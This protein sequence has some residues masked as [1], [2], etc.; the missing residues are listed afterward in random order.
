MGLA[1]IADGIFY[2]PDGLL[3]K[4][5]RFKSRVLPEIA[6]TFGAG[7]VTVTLLILGGGV[8]SYAIGFVVES[9]IRCLLTIRQ[10]RK[11]GWSLKLQMSWLSLREIVSYSKHV[12]GADLSRHIASNMDY[13]IIGRVLGAGPLGLYTLAFN[14]ANYPVLHFA[15]ILSR[16]V[17]PAFATLQENMDYARRSYL[18]VV[19]L[20]GALV[21]PLLVVLAL[22]ATPVVVGLFG[23]K[24]QPAIF[25]LQVMAIAGISRTISEPGMDMFRAMGHPNIPFKINLLEGLTIS[26]MVLLVA[27]QGI[28][29]VA[30]TVTVILS[31]ASWAIT[32]ATCR[33][34]GIS[35][36][37]LGRALVP[38][39]TLTI[40]GAAPIL[41]LKLLGLN[42]LPNALGLIVLV[43]V[44]GLAIVTCL[45]TV[46]RSLFHEIVALA[47]SVKRR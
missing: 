12:L 31:L 32:V 20:V 27:P 35:L 42:L 9:I 34:F 4:E 7:V 23:E 25:P 21:T 26:G 41:F 37:A 17:F 19:Q 47:A 16:V 46:F 14:L 22:L 29:A 10:I 15:H 3:R 8:V 28:E 2:V 38:G 24:W 30:L 5:L 18:K 45:V 33:K 40:S 6:G 11:V 1:L 39:V 43:T 36:Q 13:L 44:A